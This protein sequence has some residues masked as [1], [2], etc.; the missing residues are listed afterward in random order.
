MSS[1]AVNR[2]HRRNQYAKCRACSPSHWVGSGPTATERPEGT[3]QLSPTLVTSIFHLSCPLWP[4]TPDHGLVWGPG[5]KA[6]QL[7]SN[8]QR[9]NVSILHLYMT[10]FIWPHIRGK[11]KWPQRWAY[12]RALSKNSLKMHT[13]H[14]TEFL[15][16]ICRGQ[17]FQVIKWQV[18]GDELLQ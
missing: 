15:S 6:E 18:S 5:T 1:S 13:I 17:N 16:H 11:T 14:C 10:Y 3:S 7:E 4:R 8:S 12:E 9:S 2:C